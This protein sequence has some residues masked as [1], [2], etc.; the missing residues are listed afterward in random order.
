[1]GDYHIKRIILP[2]GKAVEIVYFDAEGEQDELAHRTLSDGL[3]L[4]ERTD[5]DEHRNLEECPCCS[6]TLVYPIDWREAPGGRWELELRCPNCEWRVRDVF[7]QEQV[8]LFDEN[9]NVATDRVI[10]A[11]ETA[12]RENMSA[13]IERFVAALEA[14]HI[15]PFDF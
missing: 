3:R 4:P 8:E 14:D 11:L 15:V 5:A 13:D 9:L 10:D 2:S 7:G 6:S 12:A 1:M